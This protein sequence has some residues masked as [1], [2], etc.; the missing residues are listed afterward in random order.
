MHTACLGLGS[1]LG[2][3]LQILHTAW[4][5]LRGETAIRAVPGELYDGAVAF[6]LEEIE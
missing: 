5:L 4:D 2:D 1:N 6:G 3:S